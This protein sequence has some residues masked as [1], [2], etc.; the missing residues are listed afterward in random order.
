MLFRS[1]INSMSKTYSV[2]G[3]RVGWMVAAPEL[4]NSIR[5]VHD[6]LT[7]GAPAP[8][9]QAAAI[10]YAYPESYYQQMAA[11]YRARR[12]FLAAPLRA[13]GFS[14]AGMSFCP[15]PA[16]ASCNGSPLKWA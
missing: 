4:T 14:F 7:V 2:T 1:T 10:G 11:E 16:A 13:A 6:F 15:M 9:Q 5:K 8:L 3:W 12:D